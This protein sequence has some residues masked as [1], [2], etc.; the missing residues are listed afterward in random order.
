M[1]PKIVSVNAL[2]VC[3]VGG[4][5]AISLF[6]PVSVR[7]QGP[8]AMPPGAGPPAN[9]N[10]KLEDRARQIHESGLRS[11]EM[12]AASESE[13]E[14]HIEAAI[15]TMKEDFTR[16]QV[17]RNDIARNLVTHKQLDYDLISHQTGEIYRRASQVNLFMM[18]HAAEDKEQSDSLEGASEE[19]IGALVRLCKLVDSFTDNPSLKNAATVDAKE[20]E[21][22]KIDKAKA[23]KDLLA[24]IKLSDRIRKK[25]DS[26]KG[27]K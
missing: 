19:M 11:V 13:T 5:L 20:I 2:T 26:F 7:G 24:I 8:G 21:K 18:A 3:L 27:V 6:Y 17:L 16:I 14:K 23:D 10:P 4:V 1:K 15:V 9:N 22:A 12:D 25:S